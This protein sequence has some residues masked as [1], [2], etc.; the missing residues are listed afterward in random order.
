MF[1]SETACIYFYMLK[2]MNS[3]LLIQSR[4]IYYTI[5]ISHEIIIANSNKNVNGDLWR[6]IM[7]S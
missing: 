4:F 2:Y 1:Y 7:K 6:Q 3:V 5:E